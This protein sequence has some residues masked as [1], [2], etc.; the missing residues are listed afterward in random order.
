MTPQLLE[1]QLSLWP[2]LI[3]GK[4]RL[5]NLSENHT[6]LVQTP[7]RQAHI[8]RVHRPDYQTEAAIKSE[9][10]WLEAVRAQTDIPVVQ[11]LAGVNGALVQRLHI[12]AA[13]TKSF[14]VRFK[15]APG[16]VA[17]TLTDLDGFFATL[18]EIA[19]NCHKHAENWPL[20]EGFERP[21]WDTGTIL[22]ADG[23]WGNW[24][25]APHVEGDV[26]STLGQL[27]AKLRSAFK[28]YGT[29]S[30]RF[31]LVHADMRLANLLVEDT[32]VRLIDFDDCGF[33][34]FVYDLGAAVS[35]FEDSPKVPQLKAQWLKS[36][37][38]VRDFSAEDEHMLDA[39][40]LLR[41]MALLAWIGSHHEVDLAKNHAPNF[42]KVSAELAKTYL[43]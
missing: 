42:A 12:D 32:Q 36:Y 20:P 34:W 25:T 4:A 5:I 21:T 35:F 16:E 8:I 28:A 27:D 40:I 1:R 6:F 30:D 38:N 3:G 26:A 41:R 39:A 10:T 9:L 23:L 2:G 11:P 29:A 19:A 31:G 24:R 15:F 37:R 18:G 14:A 33:G 13:G 17:E 43:G 7:D 22:D